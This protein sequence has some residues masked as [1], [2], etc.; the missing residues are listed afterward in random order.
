VCPGPDTPA[1]RRTADW[2]D[3]L[4]KVEFKPS[5]KL[6]DHHKAYVLDYKIRE[7]GL[8]VTVKIE[9]RP[10]YSSQPQIAAVAVETP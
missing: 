8:L 3:K 7:D 10:D 1:L 4:D 5:M 2:L 9:R 6:G